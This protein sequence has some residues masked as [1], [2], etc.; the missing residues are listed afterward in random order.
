MSSPRIAP[1]RATTSQRSGAA[2]PNSENGTVKRIGSGFHDGPFVVTR[3]RWRISRPQ[4][5]QDHGS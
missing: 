4:I 1:A 5:S 3:S 2:S